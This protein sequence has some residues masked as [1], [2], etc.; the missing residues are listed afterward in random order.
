MLH[1]TYVLVVAQRCMRGAT[2]RSYDHTRTQPPTTRLR[3]TI[4]L[5]RSIAAQRPHYTT[6]SVQ[7]TRDHVLEAVIDD[8]ARR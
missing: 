5:T 3:A 2:R 7:S 6:A 1:P 4:Y 8:V